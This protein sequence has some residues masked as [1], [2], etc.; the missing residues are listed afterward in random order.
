MK[1]KK[2]LP[3]LFALVLCFQLIPMSLAADTEDGA[4]SAVQDASSQMSTTFDLSKLEEDGWHLRPITMAELAEAVAKNRG[5]SYAEALVDVRN[6]PSPQATGNERYEVYKI[7]TV[8]IDPAGTTKTQFRH[9]VAVELNSSGSFAMI[10][11]VHMDSVG[12]TPGSGPLSWETGSNYVG[13]W[14]SNYIEFISTGNATLT[15]ST[16]I[17]VN[18]T[19]VSASVG[20][21]YY[22]RSGQNFTS[23]R[24]FR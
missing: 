17:T 8:S 9:S 15:T 7:Y 3:T 16:A 24:T 12:V 1:L 19:V 14:N 4:A 22:Y 10:A 6:R 5:I 2:V 11:S 20:S 21:N 13:S 18:A 23:S